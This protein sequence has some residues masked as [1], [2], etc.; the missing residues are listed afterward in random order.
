M[1]KATNRAGRYGRGG[2]PKIAETEQR[3][4]HILRVAGETFLHFGFDGTTM[5]AVAEAARISKRTLYARYSEKTVLFNAVLLDLINRWLI[6]IDQFQSGQGGLEDTLLALAHYLTTFALTPQCISVNRIII[7]EAQRQPE[8]G[9]LANEAGRKPA[10]RA[11]VSILRRHDTELQ[12]IDL[13]MAAEQFMSLAVDSHL[14]LAYLGIKVSPQQI[15]QWGRAAVDLFLVGV[16]HQNFS[17]VKRVGRPR[18]RKDEKE[19]PT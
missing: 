4:E 19:G 17:K 13:D 11:I 12:P 15:E 9:R 1:I 7:A 8:F 6:P 2:R 16:K 18:A 10:I 3:D 14:R 5:D